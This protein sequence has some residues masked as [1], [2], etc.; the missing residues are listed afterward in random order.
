M[1]VTSKGGRILGYARVSTEDQNLDMQIEALKKAGVHPNHMFVEKVSAAAKNRPKLKLLLKSLR[2]DDR[3]VFWKF[4]RLARN[5]ME[6]H[7][8]IDQIK[9]AGAEYISITEH[10]DTSTPAGKLMLNMI[11]AFAQ[12]ERDMTIDRTRAGVAAA[13]ARGVQFGQPKKIKDKAVVA[14]IKKWRKERVP[15]REI[16]RRLLA[17]DKLKVSVTTIDKYA[18]GK[19]KI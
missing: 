18:T 13:K 5:V 17:D 19:T 6:L 12:F 9:A 11:A 8:R 10:V 7:T 3:V 14:K 4:D 15:F 1:G 16:Q 2:Q